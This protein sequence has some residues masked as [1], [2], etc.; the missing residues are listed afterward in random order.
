MKYHTE[1]VREG[2]L[3]GPIDWNHPFIDSFQHHCCSD[4]QKQ[5]YCDAA[6]TVLR[7]TC[8]LNAAG[9]SIEVRCGEYWYRVLGIGMYDGWPFWKPM[10]AV[11][12]RDRVFGVAI[13]KFFYE[14]E[15]VRTST[16]GI[17]T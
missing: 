1:I 11:C 8:E 2:E 15:D 14:L 3:L 13:W 4:A 9:E 10:P 7:R 12:V 17:E 5:E 6:L 16:K